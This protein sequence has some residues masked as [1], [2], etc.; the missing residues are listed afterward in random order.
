MAL[1]DTIAYILPFDLFFSQPREFTSG[2][3]LL[4]QTDSKEKVRCVPTAI[5]DHPCSM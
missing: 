2:A 3:M 4:N 1:S 5:A